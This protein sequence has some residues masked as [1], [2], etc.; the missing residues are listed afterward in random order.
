MPN[1]C[2]NYVTVKGP[3]KKIAP[4]Y[5]AVKQEKFCNAVIPVP[6]DLL[7]EAKVGDKGKEVD[8]R[9]AKHGYAS[10]YDFCVDKWGTKW[11]VGNDDP[12]LVDRGKT[13]GFGFDSAWSP[14]IG[15]YRELEAQG[16][17]V[18]AYYWEPGMCFAGKYSDGDDDFYDYSDCNGSEEIAKFLPEEINDWFDI[19]QSI[20]DWEEDEIIEVE[21]DDLPPD[22]TEN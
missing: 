17:T 22:S 18:E 11:D 13:L 15:V 6:E 3:K 21:G 12:E 5:E 10:W 16:Y 7:V 14:P 19:S 2:S 1:W 20:A 9:I 4:L 8:A